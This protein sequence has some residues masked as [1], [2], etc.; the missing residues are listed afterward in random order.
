MRGGVGSQ[1]MNTST[2]ADDTG[3]DEGKEEGAGR[4]IRESRSDCWG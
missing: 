1:G 2:G 4:I 3:K